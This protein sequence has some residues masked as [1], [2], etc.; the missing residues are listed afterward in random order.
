MEN[1]LIIKHLEIQQITQ[2]NTNPGYANFDWVTNENA[3]DNTIKLK[4]AIGYIFK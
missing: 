4:E 3:T 2:S 1:Y